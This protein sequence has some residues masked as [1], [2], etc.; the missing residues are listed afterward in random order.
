MKFSIY[1]FLYTEETLKHDC[2][3]NISAAPNFEYAKIRKH[4]LYQQ[5]WIIVHSLIACQITDTVNNCIMY[6]LTGANQQAPL[7]QRD[8]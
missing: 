7:L 1:P 6:Q 2:V 5:Y 8:T 3:N 4:Q